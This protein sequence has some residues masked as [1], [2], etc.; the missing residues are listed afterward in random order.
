MAKRK[1]AARTS[2][3][4]L[5]VISRGEVDRLTR[6]TGWNFARSLRFLIEAGRAA[7]YGQ[8]AMIKNHRKVL[9]LASQIRTAEERNSDKLKTK[10]A[11][12][13]AAQNA[14]KLT[15]PDIADA[16]GIGGEK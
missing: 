1:K 4:R 11:E 10:R 7:L 13:R 8:D 15:G 14:A 5:D 12:L 9:E 6:S 2:P 16:S 3:V